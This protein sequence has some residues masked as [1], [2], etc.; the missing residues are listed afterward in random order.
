[1]DYGFVRGKQTTKNENGPL[2]T[3]CD[4]YNCYLLIV[5]EY[6]QHLWIFLFSNNSPPITTVT[7][8]LSNH[9]TISGLRRVRTDQGGELA[10]SIE[11]RKCIHKAGYTLDTTGAGASFQNTIMERPHRQLGNMMHTMLSGSNLDSTY[12]S[13]AIR[14]AMYI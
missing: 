14:Y 4:G 10:K 5:N 6:S 1:M 12:W 11:F 7:S 9:N 8:F 3:S 2:V 13:H